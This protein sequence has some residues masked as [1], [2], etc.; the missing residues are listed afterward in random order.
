MY[1]S[2]MRAAVGYALDKLNLSSR[3]S[4]TRACRRERTSRAEAKLKEST[5]V[6]QMRNEKTTAHRG[7]NLDDELM[8]TLS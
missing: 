3:R 8:E 5:T 4:K 1:R 6:Y 2:E 7:A